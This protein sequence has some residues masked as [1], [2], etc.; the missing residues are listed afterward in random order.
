MGHSKL[1]AAAL[2]GAVYGLGAATAVGQEKEITLWS[3]WADQQTKVAFIEEVARRFEEKNAGTDVKITWYQKNPLNEA[4]K[5]AL[6]AGQAPDIFYCEPGQT[7]YVEN[8]FLLDLTD[9]IDWTNVEDWARAT[10]THDGKTYAIPLEAFTVELYTNME[11]LQELGVTLPESRQL[12]QAEFLDLVRKAAAAG[13]TPIVVGVGDRPFPGAY[14]TQELLLK[15]LGTEDYDRLLKGELAWTDQ[16]VVDVLNYVKQLVDAGAFPPSISTMKLG[17]S[18]TYF[19]SNPGGLTLPMGSW[20]TSRAFN[21]P[22]QGGQP[23]DFPLGIMQFPAPDGAACP[24]CKTAATGGSFCVNADSDNADLAAG[25]LSEMATPEMG[26]EW[27]KTILVQTGVKS[28][29]SAITGEHKD[30]FDEL[31]AVNENAKFYSGG[32]PDAAM[33]GEYRE[34]F[35]QVINAALPAGQIEVDDAVETMNQA[36]GQG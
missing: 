10:W 15:K 26:T 4:V 7:E 31:Q 13:L 2:L 24:E 32:I 8:G 30:Y 1:L 33:Q 21:P 29:P 19:Y 16:R 18:H 14:L 23:A 9:K 11:K 6:Q 36:C 35:R 25:L 20:Y 22:E 5:A 28:D 3:H 17:E 12:S 27:L 34:A